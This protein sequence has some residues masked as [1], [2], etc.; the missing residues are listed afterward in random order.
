V[1]MLAPGV[2]PAGLA[3]RVQQFAPA[4]IEVDTTTLEPWE[5]QTLARLI[6]ASDILHAIFLVQ[7]SPHNPGWRKRL[8]GERGV[9]QKAALEYFDIMA[10][11]WDRLEHDAPFLDVGPKP[12]GA[13]FYPEDLTKQ[14][15]SAWLM[16]HPEDRENFTSPFT[17]IER[18]LGKLI[19]VPYSRKYSGVLVRA[20]TLLQQAATLAKPH[21]ASLAAF[22]SSRGDAFVS[23]DYYASD[24]AWMDIHDSRIEPTIGPYEV[25]EDRLEGLKA[26]FESFV[27]L[28]DSAASA[29]LEQLKSHLRDLEAAL[30]EDD[31]YKNL[32]RQFQ[33]PI[34]VVEVA[35]SAGDARR[36]VQSIA[37]NLPNDE[38]VRQRKGSKQV[39][40]RN[41]AQAKFDKMLV[42]I[43]NHVLDPSLASA[44]RFDPWFTNVLMHELAHG[45]GPGYVTGADGR[46]T[47]QTVNQ[48]LRD[49]YSAIEEAKADVTGLHDLTVLE[50]KGVF[51]A[52]FVRRAF[53]GHFADL[54]R[55]VRFGTGEAH[56]KANL[57]QFDWL[58]RKGV[59]QVDSTG[60]FTVDLPRY[61]RENRVLAHEL[62]TIEATGDYGGAV[63][64][65]Q[66]YGTEPPAL[67]HAIASLTDV[68]VDIRPIY[69]AAQW[70]EG[71]RKP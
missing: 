67:Q 46:R 14:D 26:S 36:G 6:E 65:L 4:V 71:W 49:R 69:P 58:W 13:G 38:R 61:I 35:Y 15:F 51:D 28:T 1:S 29:E 48:A 52:D 22:L 2:T 20:D 53:I 5:K 66:Q 60:H 30:P 40:L 18:E 11:P 3:R 8:A 54:F 16:N 68:P 59:T 63:R 10:G 47:G 55:A 62:L 34:R 31:R 56:G 50:Q 41:V 70:A 33:S 45:L 17:V 25:Y 21:N 32:D 7:V 39:M 57:L 43:A 44:I 64:L 24:L 42:P 19:A 37:F 23:N 27:T 9:G 12:L